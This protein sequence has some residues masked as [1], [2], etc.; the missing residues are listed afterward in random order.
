M[1]FHK[2]TRRELQALCK[3]NKIPANTTNVAMVDAL[4]SLPQ[5]EGLE[6]LL[7]PDS[8]ANPE[9]GS[10]NVT[11]TVRRASRRKPITNEPESA[12]TVT[13]T[14]RRST[15]RGVT[16]EVPETPAAQTNRKI[17]T[18][19]STRKKLD[20]QLGEEK[21]NDQSAVQRSTRRSVR[22]SEKKIMEKRKT[23]G[24]KMNPIKIDEL[25]EDLSKDLK[26]NESEEDVGIIPD[27]VSAKSE[28]VDVVLSEIADNEI[29]FKENV[30][31]KIENGIGFGINSD[32]AAVPDGELMNKEVDEEETHHETNLMEGT[33]ES[34]DG[35]DN[36]P[37]ENPELNINAS[38]EK[39]DP[40]KLSVVVVPSTAA[41]PTEV[42]EVVV[43]DISA[44]EIINSEEAGDDGV[45][46]FSGES[47]ADGIE[48]EV[49]GL[50][51]EFQ[52][53]KGVS[54]AIPGEEDHHGTD[55]IDL[56]D[57]DIVEELIVEGFC[58]KKSS[59]VQANLNNVNEANAEHLQILI[60]DEVKSSEVQENLNNV[61]E[62]NA[63]HLQT[64]ISDEVVSVEKSEVI[65]ENAV[66]DSAT[67]H[68]IVADLEFVDEMNSETPTEDPIDSADDFL[69]N[70]EKSATITQVSEVVEENFAEEPTDKSPK[71]LDKCPIT[72][73]LS[74]DATGNMANHH[75][76]HVL[77]P[78]QQSSREP[79]TVQTVP[80]VSGNKENVDNSGTV[81]MKNKEENPVD[82]QKASLR[83]LKK[84]FKQKLQITDGT[85]MKKDENDVKTSEQATLTGNPPSASIA[86][87]RSNAKKCTTLNLYLEAEQGQQDL[88]PQQ[89]VALKDWDP[90][91]S[92]QLHQEEK[93]QAE[94]AENASS[95]SIVT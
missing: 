79:T 45:L 1:D 60:S 71:Q 93:Q 57:F 51:M 30:A 5:V 9:I 22:L 68:A 27:E 86:V 54:I 80:Q 56:S 84:M 36:L 88:L 94:M 8:S 67:V 35:P 6:D 83:Q 87:N 58:D 21:E 38:P 52:D 66:N 16:E 31:Q 46:K 62:A 29:E 15:R 28:M 89:H 59:E 23:E 69:P 39:I 11:T 91:S 64:L 78:K 53:K 37:S 92:Q 48:V 50:E 19:A 47:V 90:T 74:D 25:C 55:G 42:L 20:T 12:Q 72:M 75:I 41:N 49:K 40:V 10:P 81:V 63:E 85:N 73:K 34:N 82:L 33:E 32:E 26:I 65:L 14:T 3:K 18:M 77:K 43:Q 17:E 24:L 13:R 44:E 4:A 95:L 76:S 61:N 7:N 2:L 70:P